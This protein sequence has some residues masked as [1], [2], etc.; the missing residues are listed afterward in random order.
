MGGR[1]SLSRLVVGALAIA[2]ASLAPLRVGPVA[3]QEQP[4]K[5]SSPAA[6]AGGPFVLIDHRGQAVT[7]KD[8]RGR[9]L[10]ILF[11][12]TFCPDVCPT[13]LNTASLALDAL[14]ASAD[15]VVPVF[16]TVDPTRDTPSVLADYVPLFHPRL[17]GLTGSK[18]QIAGVARAYGVRYFKLYLPP[19]QDDDR[20][21]GKGGDNSEYLLNHSAATYLVGTEGR[22]LTVFPHGT[23]PERMAVAME[24]LM[25]APTPRSAKP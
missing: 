9:F 13:G 2:L 14:G 5:N 1:L 10:L 20:S 24:R 4:S 6:V 7:D 23:P 11:G 15:R 25:N 21:D 22:V 16:I 3:A 18:E 19:F 17:V 12:Y 8:Y